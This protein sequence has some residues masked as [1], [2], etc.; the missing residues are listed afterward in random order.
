MSRITTTT[1]A[2]LSTVLLSTGVAAC[3]N[4]PAASSSGAS[5]TAASSKKVGATLLSLQYPFLVTLDDAMKAQAE[6]SGVELTS[7][8]PRQST[9]TELSQ[10]EDL[11][12]KKV[13]AIIMIP[14]DQKASQAAA[15]K[16]NQA[17][18]PLVLV[19]TRFSDDFT[20][21]SVT[22]VGS[23][24]TEAGQIEG[25]YALDQL[26]Q[27][28]NIIYLVGQYGG[29][30]TE[31]RK[32][33]FDETIKGSS[34]NVSTEIEAKGSRA[35]AK[36]VMENLL[37]RYSTKGEISGIVAQSDEMAIGAASAIKE[38]NRSDEFKFIIGVD[39]SEAGLKAVQSGDITATVFQD[40]VGQGT[41][42]MEVTADYLAGKTVDKEYV[43]P[44]QL[45]TKDNLDQFLK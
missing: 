6:K 27:G 21:E 3:S 36:T 37:R 8:D 42:A 18:I 19:N 10:I 2:I 28:G 1:A 7:L 45:V 16:V 33:G 14:V 35:D 11:I 9:A 17:K 26:P 38:A 43:I 40:A 15:A 29:A 39:G 5:S 4:S 20:G 32:A 22:Y 13:D 23:D 25:Q 12:T 41:K 31:R 24:D 44:F 34:I 30:S